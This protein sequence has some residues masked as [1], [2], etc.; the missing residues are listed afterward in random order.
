VH[1][2]QV[3]GFP[4]NRLGG[5]EV[6]IG[7]LAR[8]LAA[9]GLRSTLVAPRNE[10]DPP[11]SEHAG[12]M[13]ETYP[14]NATPTHDE[15]RSGGAHQEFEEFRR[16]LTRHSGAIYHQHSWTRG[17]GIHHLRAARD[18]GLRTVLTVHTPNNF[19]LRGD[20]MRF[21]K[22]SC[23]GHVDA[24]TCAKCWSQSRGA[25][26]VLARGLSR[27]PLAAS[28]AAHRR[29]GR[30]ATALSAHALADEKGRDLRA[31][32]DNCDRIVAVCS[33]VHEALL[34]N[35]APRG[36][37]CLNRQ[38][39]SAD[40]A[41]RAGAM[42]GSTGS[43]EAKLKMIYVGR[44][45]PVK[46]VDVVVRAVRSLPADLDVQLT[47]CAPSDGL[48]RNDY[49]EGVRALA[50]GDRRILIRGAEPHA[51]LAATLSQYHVIV[52][53]SLWME[54]GP[55]VV[56][57]GQAAGLFVIGSRRGGIAELIDENNAGMLVEPGNVVAWGAA[58]R[59]VAERR[60]REGLA[61]PRGAVRTMTRVAEDMAELYRSLERVAA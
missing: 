54:T 39:V 53:P 42:N 32:I 12:A 44:W 60:R 6:Y 55:L 7:E 49:E 18:A 37:I 17:C 24:V 47:I 38:G 19:C 57:E 36:K 21:G 40:F 58:I 34:L 13:V 10:G 4:P 51:T 22:S 56:L 35:G 33:W 31:M 9:H 50:D 15:I 5:T 23:D 1:I 43:G 61:A 8:G 11:I 45:D 2:L 16:L 48:E 52:V 27:L 29:D 3:S 30:L 41:L 28:R 25:P 20:M 26:S 46:G 59:Q 14:V